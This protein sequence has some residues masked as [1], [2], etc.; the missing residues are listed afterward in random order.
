MVK[1][2]VSERGSAWDF[3]SVYFLLNKCLQIGERRKL[4]NQILKI[5]KKIMILQQMV[6]FFFLMCMHCVY[7][8]E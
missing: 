2:D 1:N 7:V 3:S 5:G 4:Q 8:C 6:S